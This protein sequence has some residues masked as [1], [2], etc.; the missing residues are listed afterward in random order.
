VI[1]VPLRSVSGQLL[2]RGAV[3][4]GV[5]GVLFSVLSRSVFSF[6]RRGSLDESVFRS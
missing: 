3:F 5:C 4:F 6:F 1:Y 2:F